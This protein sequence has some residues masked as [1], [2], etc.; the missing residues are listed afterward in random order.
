MLEIVKVT[1][2]KELDS[3]RKLFLA[4][5]EWIGVD[6]SFQNFNEELENLPGDY[7]PP[8]GC[9][10]L[11]LYNGEAAGCIAIRKLDGDIC[12]MKRLYV[13][14]EFQGHG[15]GK[16]LAE[17]V[18]LAAKGLG[19]AK[20]RLDTMPMMASAQGLYRSLGFKEIES[21]RFNPVPG[22]VFMELNLIATEDT[23]E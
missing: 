23:E 18:I 12:E 13:L 2:G 11:A 20:M 4:Y 1:G 15:I 3:V 16:S 10:L 9:L 6:L 7:A 14:P 21:Y 22:T 8:A 19:Y 5:A 17:E